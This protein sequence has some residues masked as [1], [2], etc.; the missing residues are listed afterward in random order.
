[1]STRPFLHDTV[2]GLISAAGGTPRPPGHQHDGVRHRALRAWAV[3]YVAPVPAAVR[4]MAAEYLT[5]T[6]PYGEQMLGILD[7]EG[8]FNSG[9]LV[10]REET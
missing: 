5:G 10:V 4:S 9:R 7:L 3:P 1:M 8:L 2:V 6:A